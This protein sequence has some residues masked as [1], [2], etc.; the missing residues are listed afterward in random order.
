MAGKIQLMVCMTGVCMAGG[1]HSRGH[2]W[3][4]ACMVGGMHGRGIHDRR[5][6]WQGSMHGSGHVWWGA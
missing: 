5:C 4:G 2:V 6:A 1:M 3:Q